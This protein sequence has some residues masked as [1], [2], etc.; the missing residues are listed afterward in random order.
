MGDFIQMKR[1]TVNGFSY[2]Q[3][4]LVGVTLGSP[5]APS[6]DQP[7]VRQRIERQFA[8]HHDKMW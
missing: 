4:T 8:V 5:D 3:E 2:M 6:V 7:E 1:A